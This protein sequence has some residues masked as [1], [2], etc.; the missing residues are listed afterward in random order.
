MFEPSH[1]HV[2]IGA[3]TRDSDDVL[4]P[5]FD[6]V[7]R[8]TVFGA[9]VPE[10]TLAHPAVKVGASGSRSELRLSFVRGADIALGRDPA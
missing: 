3:L 8:G 1:A 7:G 10:E 9:V 4:H 5:S 2:G 6:P